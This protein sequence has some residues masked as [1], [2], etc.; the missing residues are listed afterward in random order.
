VTTLA[1]FA[2]TDRSDT[3]RRTADYALAS[4]GFSSA[5]VDVATGDQRLGG[6]DALAGGPHAGADVSPVLVTNSIADAGKAASYA[7]SHRSTLTNGDALGGPT[8]LPD[9][10]LATIQKAAR[11]APIGYDIS[12]PQCASGTYPANAAFGIVGVNGGKPFTPNPC[13]ASEYQWALAAPRPPQFYVNTAD[14]GPASPQWNPATSEPKP[15]CDGTADNLD[16]AYNY[17]VHAA[18]DAF[19]SADTTTGGAAA[20]HTWWLDVETA[21]SW[22]STSKPANAAAVHGFV[23]YL[24]AQPG[25]SVGIYSTGYQWGVITGT[26]SG[27]ETLPNWVPGAGT[28][29]QAASYCTPARS[30][31]GGPV[32]MTQFPLNGF[33]GDYLC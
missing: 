15:G 2:G 19:T 20:N 3:A 8:A 11:G 27:F 22:S 6:A 23:D 13:L 28:E 4:L 26:P 25:V 9:S 12:F 24:V 7:A 21:N 30:F 5:H 18:Q 29:A 33:D 31:T 14:P 1:R 16:C 10:T 32:V 17:G